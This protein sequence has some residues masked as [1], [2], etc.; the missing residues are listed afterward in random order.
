MS[1]QKHLRN[2][3]LAG[4]FAAIPIAATAFIVY[5]VEKTTRELF[6]VNV[7]FLAL[8]LALAAIYVLGL[9][10]RSFIGKF[11]INLIDR[12]LSRIP[13]L[14]DLYEAWKHVS[15][16][17]GGKEGIY[18]KVVL[19]GGEGSQRYL[20]FTSGEPIEGDPATLCVFMP[21]A[22]NPV[23]GRIIFARRSDCIVLDLPVEEA[24]KIILSSGNYVPATLGSSTR[25]GSLSGSGS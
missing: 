20:G 7:P 22:P 2:T 18:A 11:L 23:S 4:A 25:V 15:I 5:Y 6:H 24:F 16:T 12:V 13:V 17:P 21:A 19:V 3:F 1:L 8:L 9:I 10:V 14:R